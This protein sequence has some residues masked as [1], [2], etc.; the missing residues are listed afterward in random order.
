M[1]KP[2]CLAEGMSR[3]R[4]ELVKHFCSMKW[5]EKEFSIIKK[6]KSSSWSLYVSGKLGF[7]KN[8]NEVISFV[9]EL[10]E[11]WE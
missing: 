8:I 2:V 3:A 4:A 9:K 5:A 11:E 10:T 7:N 1:I 6:K